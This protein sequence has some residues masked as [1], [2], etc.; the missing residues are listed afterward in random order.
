MG[1]TPGTGGSRRP[2]SVDAT[3]RPATLRDVVAITR[4][5]AFHVVHGTGSWEYEPPDEREIATRFHGVRSE[6]FPY[7]VAERA[8]EVVGYAFASH[9]RTRIGYRFTCEDSV[10]VAPLARGQGVGRTLLASLIEQCTALRMRHM[11]AVIGDVENAA[12]VALHRSCGFELIADAPNIG[13]KSGRSLG[14]LLMTRDLA[15]EPIVPSLDL[16]VDDPTSTVGRALLEGFGIEQAALSRGP[17]SWTLEQALPAARFIVARLDGQPAGCGFIPVDG[18]AGAMVPIVYAVPW[19]RE[20][21]VEDAL[22]KALA[23]MVSSGDAT[24]SDTRQAQCPHR[25]NA[26]AQGALSIGLR[27]RDRQS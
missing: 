1:D 20:H 13:W 6:G 14:W 18:A 24:L 5:Y 22:S 17:A 7:L 4:I 12:S 15:S 27:N 26:G 9:F 2:G 23:A 3:I 19:A 16:S 10:Y 25:S 21:G 11:T 8:G